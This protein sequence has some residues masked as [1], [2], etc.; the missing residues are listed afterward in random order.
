M[1]D[2]SNQALNQRL[3]SLE[4]QFSAFLAGVVEPGELTGAQRKTFENALYPIING[5]RARKGVNNVDYTSWQVGDQIIE[6]D[7]ANKLQIV[8]E[9]ISTPFNPSSDIDDV[10]KFDLYKKDQPAL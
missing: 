2:I 10:S 6:I 9:V 4:L 7:T 3:T 1:A 5:F 8:W